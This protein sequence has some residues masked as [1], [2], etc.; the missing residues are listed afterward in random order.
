MTKPRISVIHR[1]AFPAI[2]IE[3]CQEPA[4]S[5]TTGAT[6]LDS[7]RL[8]SWTIDF[9]SRRLSSGGTEVNVS[10]RAIDVLKELVKAGTATVS[11]H[12]LLDAVWPNV[13]VTDE[14]LTQAV[15]ELRRAFRADGLD[16]RMIAT[17]SRTGY[18]LLTKPMTTGGV[19]GTDPNKTAPMDL[20]A[21][22][23]I[24]EAESL[25]VRA[26][27]GAVAN[28]VECGRE[29]VEIA[30]DCAQANSFY[31]YALAVRG[32]YGAGDRRDFAKALA[33]AE[34]ATR[35]LKTSSESHAALGYVLSALESYGD[36]KDRFTASIT[37][38]DTSGEGHYLAARHAFAAGEHRIAFGLCLRT[39]ELVSDPSRPL[40]LAARSARHFDTAKSGRV[41]ERC[42]AALRQKLARDPYDVRSL[43]TLGP[44]LALAGQ[45]ET[46]W[47]NLNDIPQVDTYCAIHLA[48][49]YGALGETRLAMEAIERAVDEGYRDPRWL[50]QEDTLKHLHSN[51]RFMR[52][53]ELLA[54]A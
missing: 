4:F 14:S 30:P 19:S 27:S 29:V 8:G 52:L 25:L 42:V 49:G 18:R 35:V 1:A 37:Q 13:T 50:L 28:A 33:Y 41:A 6:M 34:R 11:R 10:P 17:V 47:K 53:N 44:A 15:S 54:A 45:P 16:T 39:A 21:Y 3:N 36:A 46:A 38:G 24:V 12:A 40:F 23:L 31:A 32:L 43:Y 26:E 5:E 22:A 2:L 9:T 48:F 51:P 20:A 7:V